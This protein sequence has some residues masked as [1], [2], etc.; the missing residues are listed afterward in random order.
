M[1]NPLEPNERLQNLGKEM[2]IMKKNQVKIIEL[3]NA[4][5]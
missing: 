2:L 4:L 1:T 3:K 5:T